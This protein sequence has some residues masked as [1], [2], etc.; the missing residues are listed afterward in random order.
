MK[1]NFTLLF[2]VFCLVPKTSGQTSVTPILKGKI[3]VNSVLVEGVNISNV[4]SQE[5]TT[6]NKN[7]TFILPVKPGEII[8]F[9]AVNLEPFRK[10]ISLQDLEYGILEIKMESKN[11]VL[12]EV[13]I[14]E[15]PELT[16]ENLR[17]I[18]SG[19]R[20]YTAAERKLKTAGDF[21]PIQLLGIL[22]GALAIDPILNAISGRTKM[23]KKEVQ[24]ERKEQLLSKI[25]VVFEEEYYSKTLGIPANY[26]KGFHYYC[27]E[28]AEFA[29]ALQSKNKTMMQFLI[30]KLAE[31]YNALLADEKN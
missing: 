29:A 8:L 16:A 27:I 24:V 25:E 18:P 9:S 10:R 17:I 7:G 20:K 23:L 11:N 15:H 14:N 22:G 5:T 28:D 12:K 26:I 31:K 4:T 1:N 2:F 19:Q 3:T 30:V 13:I 21:K 6:T